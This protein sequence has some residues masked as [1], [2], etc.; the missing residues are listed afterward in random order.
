M[1]ILLAIDDSE[2]GEAALRMV[3]TQ[4]RPES[5]AV[6]LIT[7]LEPII[8]LAFSETPVAYG[9]QLDE[10]LRNRHKR[11]TALLSRFARKLKD[12][13]FRVTTALLEGDVRRSIVQAAEKW[14]ANLIVVGSHSRRGLSRVVLGSVSEFVARHALCSVQIVR[15]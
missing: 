14:K 4:N 13:G 6:R 7:V 1:R 15:K 2:Y 9:K 11:A 3:A 5:N 8:P 10:I 12:K